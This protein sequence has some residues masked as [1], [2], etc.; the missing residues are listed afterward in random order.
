[1]VRLEL[2]LPRARDRPGD[3]VPLASDRLVARGRARRRPPAS[4]TRPV[5][6]RP[7][8]LPAP[9]Q[10]RRRRA[11][12]LPRRSTGST[13]SLPVYASCSQRS[14]PRAPSGCSSTSPRSSAR[15]STTPRDAR[16]RRRSA[17]LRR[18]R[19]RRRPPGDLRRRALRLA[20]RRAPGA[21]RGPDRGDRA[22]P[23]ARARS[24]RSS[25][26]DRR[27][28]RAKT[29]VGGV[30]DGH[31]IWRGDLAAAFDKL[32]ALRAVSPNVVGRRPRRRCS[33]C[34]TT[35]TT[36]PSSTARLEELA[37]LRRPEGRPGRGARPR[38]ARGTRRDRRP[39]STR[40]PPPSPT[41]PP[42]PACA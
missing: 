19:R 5:D 14:P 29:L 27:V 36:R 8:H 16:A 41:A 32:E 15:A 23:G 42:R 20:R 26:R 25:T 18:A 40:H 6:R 35:S 9:E 28:A 22:R 31:N 33:T 24:R 7:G 38:A 21:R 39:S 11:R 17:R 10:G 4:R 34:R 12:G 37:R 13:T 30:I 2:P 1:M 3:R